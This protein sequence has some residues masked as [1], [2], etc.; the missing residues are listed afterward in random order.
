MINFKAK[1]MGGYL[2][3]KVSQLTSLSKINEI[4]TVCKFDNG[5]STGSSRTVHNCLSIRKLSY[6]E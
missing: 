2:W 6:Q 5:A 4:R 3:R 1:Q